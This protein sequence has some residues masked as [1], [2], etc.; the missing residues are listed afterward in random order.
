MSDPFGLGEFAACKHE[1]LRCEQ[2][3]ARSNIFGWQA[4]TDY[5]EIRQQ[6]AEARAALDPFAKVADLIDEL[7]GT[8]LVVPRTPHTAEEYR[9]ARKALQ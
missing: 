1:T 6:L 2:C 8:D 4:Y 5:D 9:A 7:C 3:G